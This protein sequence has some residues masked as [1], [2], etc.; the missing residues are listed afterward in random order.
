M[1][2]QLEQHLYM[3]I[4]IKGAVAKGRGENTQ[5]YQRK[6]RYTHY[7][8]EKRCSRVWQIWGGGGGE[9]NLKQNL[10]NISVISSPALNLR[11]QTNYKG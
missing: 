10:R 4:K 7:P 6:R 11:I 3:E 1:E 8:W 9:V 2:T 5:F